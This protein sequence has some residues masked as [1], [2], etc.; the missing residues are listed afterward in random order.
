[1]RHDLEQAH[2]GQVADVGQQG[3][4]LG[5]Q[6]VAPQPEHLEAGHRGAQV[7]HE[8]GAVEVARRL[9]ARDEKSRRAQAGAV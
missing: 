7:A 4:A 9:A 8:L 5:L 6:P 1:M 2:H 3:G